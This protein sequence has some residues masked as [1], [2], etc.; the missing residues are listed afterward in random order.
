MSPKE[1]LIRAIDAYVRAP[2]HTS[3]TRALCEELT[4]LRDQ[5]AKEPNPV[6]R[7]VDAK[8]GLL[9]HAPMLAGSS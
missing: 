7:Q 6:A 1:D 4:G 3:G 9:D 2:A 8:H 5:V